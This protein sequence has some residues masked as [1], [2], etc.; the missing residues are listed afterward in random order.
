[1][2]STALYL[3]DMWDSFAG[4]RGPKYEIDHSAPLITRVSVWC[5]ILLYTAVSTVEVS[6]MKMRE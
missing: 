6:N 1:M 4:V 3:T 2:D 5:F